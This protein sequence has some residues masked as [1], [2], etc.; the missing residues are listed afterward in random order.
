M[1]TTIYKIDAFWD[2]EAQVWVAQSEDVPG[3]VTEA[4]TI[5]VLT[6]KLKQMIPELLLVNHIVP[7][8]FF[9]PIYCLPSFQFSPP[10]NSVKFSLMIADKFLAG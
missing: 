5:E 6:D 10:G 8:D 2:Q 7:A 3:L 1:S 9:C 4:S